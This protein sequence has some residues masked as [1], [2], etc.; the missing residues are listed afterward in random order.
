MTGLRLGVAALLLGAGEGIGSR[1]N[2]LGILVLLAGAGMGFF[3]DRLC[4]RFAPENP[5][6]AAQIRLVG[7]ALALAGTFWAMYG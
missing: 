1:V 3:A 6:R 2:W 4:E 5:Q 7:L